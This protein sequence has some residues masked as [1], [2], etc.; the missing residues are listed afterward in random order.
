MKGQAGL[1]FYHT[2]VASSK[3]YLSGGASRLAIEVIKNIEFWR[4]S[5]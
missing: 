5:A 2:G 1:G 3:K 4:F